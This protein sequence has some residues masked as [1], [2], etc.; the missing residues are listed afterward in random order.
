[1]KQYFAYDSVA[2]AREHATS[3]KAPKSTFTS[4]SLSM[5]TTRTLSR[6]RLRINA[7]CQ[8]EIQNSILFEPHRTQDNSYCNKTEINAKVINFKS[9]SKLAASLRQTFLTFWP[10]ASTPG[11]QPAI[12][13]WAPLSRGETLQFS[14]NLSSFQQSFFNL[15]LSRLIDFE[16]QPLTCGLTRTSDTFTYRHIPNVRYF[17]RS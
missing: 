9:A 15:T 7:I 13:I 6:F 1:M 11:A 12:I 16:S 2:P 10:V 8:K 14:Q 5:H 17:Q 4:R 3:S